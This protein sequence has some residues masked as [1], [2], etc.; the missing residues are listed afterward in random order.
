MTNGP[1]AGKRELPT[2]KSLILV[3]GLFLLMFLGWFSFGAFGFYKAVISK[4]W[5]IATGT[6]ISSPEVT[7]SGKQTRYGLDILY[8]YKIDQQE[9]QSKYF[10]ETPTRGTPEWANVIDQYAAKSTVTVYYNP[11]NLKDSVIEPG[12]RSD[13]FFMTLIPLTAFVLVLLVLMQQIKKKQYR[14]DN[15]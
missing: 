13:D 8:S 15:P 9:Y 3:F 7:K 4:N 6:V 10:K 12:L 2:L 5:P 14:T 11:K 1:P